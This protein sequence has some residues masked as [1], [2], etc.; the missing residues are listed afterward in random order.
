MFRSMSFRKFHSLSLSS[1]GMRGQV[2]VV[3]QSCPYLG[4]WLSK[5]E[6]SKNRAAT[7]IA[8]GSPYLPAQG[9][10]S[11]MSRLSIPCLPDRQETPHLGQ[12]CHE[13]H[14]NVGRHQCF[15]HCDLDA[16]A[17]AR[18]SCVAQP[19]ATWGKRVCG[20]AMAVGSSQLPV[21]P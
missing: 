15:S 4:M 12:P 19:L 11:P 20:F 13:P 18:S 16:R 7:P 17:G 2:C 6:A 1:R 14:C 8:M 21:S 5:T 3:T 9:S 10:P